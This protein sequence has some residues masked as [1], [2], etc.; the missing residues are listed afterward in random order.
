MQAAGIDTNP[1]TAL[2]RHT[3]ADEDLVQ[4]LQGVMSCPEKYISHLVAS[5]AKQDKAELDRILK[6]LPMVREFK[7]K[8]EAMKCRPEEMYARPPTAAGSVQPPGRESLRSAGSTMGGGGPLLVATPRQGVPLSSM[9]MP[10]AGTEGS[11]LATPRLGSRQQGRPITP[12]V[13]GATT[14]RLATHRVAAPASK[15]GGSNPIVATPL[16]SAR[17]QHSAMSDASEERKIAWKQKLED[18]QKA[19]SQRCT[20]TLAE[21][22]VDPEGLQAAEVLQLLYARGGGSSY[23]HFNREA[24]SRC[25]VRVATPRCFTG[26]LNDRA[27]SEIRRARDMPA[28]N[29][30][31]CLDHWEIEF[32]ADV[33]R[34]LR[35][36][37]DKCQGHSSEY[38]RMTR[39]MQQQTLF[40]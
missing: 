23:T 36:F 28:A 13:R 10:E 8:R 26:V 31:E 24:A 7:A 11:R 9:L 5:R 27:F 2:L 3:P 33:C 12:A 40:R 17:R 22:G 6:H 21:L 29:V 20:Q 34:S 15:P 18:A 32:L 35:H 1:D 4:A 25:N 39:N 16:P 14:P 37:G 30:H 19:S 38:S